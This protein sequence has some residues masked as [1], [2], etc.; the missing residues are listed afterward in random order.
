[1]ALLYIDLDNMKAINDQHGHAA[2]DQALIETAELLRST[3]RES[4]IVARLGGDEFCVLL[5][6]NGIEAS[7]CIDRL[8][9]RLQARGPDTLPPI[10]LSVGIAKYHWD[11]PCP[12]ETL[13]ARAD[14]AMYQAKAE[15]RAAIGP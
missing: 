9:D 10:S 4:D 12:I 11:D 3:F 7:A 8:H 1:M 13:I 2:G 6:K 15:K 5:P 14:A